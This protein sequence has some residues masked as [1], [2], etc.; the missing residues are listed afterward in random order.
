ML[1]TYRA[2]PWM[3]LQEMNYIKVLLSRLGV[4][5]FFRRESSS[6]LGRGSRSTFRQG[7]SYCCLADLDRGGPGFYPFQRYFFSIF[8]KQDFKCPL[9]RFGEISSSLRTNLFSG[10]VSRSFQRLSSFLHVFFAECVKRRVLFFLYV[11]GLMKVLK[12]KQVFSAQ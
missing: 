9:H 3:P 1:A 8:L 7:Q 10:D 11:E 5:Q 12:V 4:A 2:N 6:L